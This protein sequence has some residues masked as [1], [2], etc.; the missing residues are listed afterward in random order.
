MNTKRQQ[1]LARAIEALSGRDLIYFVEANS[2]SSLRQDKY[3]L[4]EKLLSWAEDTLASEQ[5]EP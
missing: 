1:R 5:D 2:T 4:Q 3:L